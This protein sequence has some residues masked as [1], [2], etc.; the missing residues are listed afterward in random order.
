M[1]RKNILGS[2][3]QISTGQ[4]RQVQGKRRKSK[5]TE[6]YQHRPRLARVLLRADPLKK[7]TYHGHQ[8]GSTQSCFFLPV[9]YLFSPPLLILISLLFCC[10][11]LCRPHTVDAGRLL[12]SGI[13]G[14]RPSRAGWGRWS[15]GESHW[16]ASRGGMLSW[17]PQTGSTRSSRANGREVPIE[18]RE[19]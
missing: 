13:P 15:L 10:R 6:S 7:G 17:S 19:Q 1:T 9:R 2:Y 16:R 11:T 3:V 4:V 5:S 12:P 18:L 14:G 8:G